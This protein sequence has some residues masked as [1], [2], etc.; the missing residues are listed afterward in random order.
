MTS[1][2]HRMR[3]VAVV[4]CAGAGK[5]SFAAELGR[6]TGLPV[7]HLDHHYWH[8]GWVG[9]PREEW[10][11]VQA[12]LV[13]GD[14]WIIDGNYGSTLDLRFARA[15]TVI[16]LAPSRW[17]CLAGVLRRRLS[18]RG[19]AVQAPGCPERVTLDFLRWIWRYDRDAR[20]VL[21]A[22]LTRHREHLRIVQLTSRQQARA[23]LDRF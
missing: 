15:D 4:G 3:R 5:S 16:W 14:A 20:P 11:A 18:A 21:D 9:T 10:R 12:E 6:R 19:A 1:N 23:F 22:A 17:R 8:P 7:V 13:A 2:P